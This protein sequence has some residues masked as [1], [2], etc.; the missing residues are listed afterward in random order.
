[1]KNKIRVLS[2]FDGIAVARQALK[3]LDIDCDYYASEIDKFA[4]QTAKANHPDIIQMGDVKNVGG[5]VVDI[6]LMIGGFPCQSFSIAGNRK[7]LR[8]ERGQLFFELLRILKEVKPKYFLF[9]NVASMSKENQAF[10][11]EKLGVEPIMINSDRFVQQNRKRLYWTNI[12]IADLPERPDWQ[13]KFYQWRRTYFR[14]N[15]NGVCPT[16]TAN[17]GTGGHNI[18]LLSM[19]KNDRLSVKEVAALQGLPRDYCS[20]VSKTQAYRAIGN[21]FT[22]P[23][24]KHIL[25]GL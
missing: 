7:G 19:N 9:E 25:K 23:V 15:K 1:M 10:I 13:G 2:L 22:L 17:M 6:E 24:I 21:S 8:D 4:I 18:P 11:S 12:K 16:L 5:F 3:E 14:E 20:M